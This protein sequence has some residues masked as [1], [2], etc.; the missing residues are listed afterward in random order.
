MSI[1][2]QVKIDHNTYDLAAKYDLMV[3][4]LKVLILKKIKYLRQ[5]RL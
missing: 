5:N 3:M 2:N 1:L 4:I